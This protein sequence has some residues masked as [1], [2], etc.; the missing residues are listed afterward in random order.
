MSSFR[1]ETY[2]DVEVFFA[3]LD[4]KKR[5]SSPE[6]EAQMKLKLASSYL[7]ITW[8]TLKLTSYQPLFMTMPDLP[9]ANRISDNWGNPR[10][11]LGPAVSS[12]YY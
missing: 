5:L 8:L 12:G 6:D 1:G 3:I 11:D 2:N 4:I 7:P 9:R 10:F